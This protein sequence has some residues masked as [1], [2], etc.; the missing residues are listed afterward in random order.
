M[1]SFFSSLFS[2]TC[3]ANLTALSAQ[4][5]LEHASEH[6]CVSSLP[7]RL[8]LTASWPRLWKHIAYECSYVDCNQLK[9]EKAKRTNLTERAFSVRCP[10]SC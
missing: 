6:A 5:S 10:I 1:V 7:S 2:L 4:S 3:C 9:N 8:G